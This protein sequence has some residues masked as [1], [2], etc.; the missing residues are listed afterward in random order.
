MPEE[1]RTVTEFVARFK[2]KYPATI[3]WRY[4]KNSSVVEKHLNEGEEVLYA[5]IAQKND[6]PFH[7]FET[8]VVALTT[9]RIVIGRKRVVFGYFIDSV[10]PEMFNDL[11]IVSSIIWGKVMIDTVKEFIV[12]SNVSKK[13]LPEIYTQ[14][15]NY[16]K[17]MKKR[18]LSDASKMKV[19]EEIE[20]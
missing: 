18:L 8:C 1:K 13:A 19:K 16:M 14:V 3:G 7:I 4:K 9:E 15:S 2:S 5:F 12:L 20:S 6:N 17:I 11:K 10:T